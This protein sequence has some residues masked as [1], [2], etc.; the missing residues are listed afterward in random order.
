MDTLVC[1]PK[2]LQSQTSKDVRMVQ[3]WIG[4]DFKKNPFLDGSNRSHT[5]AMLFNLFTSWFSMDSCQV[6]FWQLCTFGSFFMDVLLAILYV[7]NS[8]TLPKKFSQR[9]LLGRFWYYQDGNIVPISQ[10]SALRERYRLM[11]P[12]RPAFPREV[13]PCTESVWALGHRGISVTCE[14]APLRAIP[15]SWLA[16]ILL[17]YLQN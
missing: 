4:D 10:S 8:Q 3:G 12:C 9:G 11:R 15:L 16:K 17:E 14:S 13:A 7:K 5:N 2:P 1:Y 6:F